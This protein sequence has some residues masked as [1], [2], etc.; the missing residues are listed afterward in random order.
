[1]SA[2]CSWLEAT[3][4][5]PKTPA[6]AAI[7]AAISSSR[8]KKISWRGSTSRTS[9]SKN[10]GRPRG[11]LCCE[12]DMKEWPRRRHARAYFRLLRLFDS[13]AS[14]LGSVPEAS[15]AGVRWPPQFR[16]AAPRAADLLLAEETHRRYFPK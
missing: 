2:S 4:S 12:D 8:E 5:S 10:I 11:Q 16:S 6:T 15:R 7:L 3:A 13:P 1:M 14:F 9:R